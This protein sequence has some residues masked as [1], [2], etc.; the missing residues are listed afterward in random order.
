MKRSAFKV[1]GRGLLGDLPDHPDFPLAG[2]AAALAPFS[3]GEFMA[4]AVNTATQT[5]GIRQKRCTSDQPQPFNHTTTI[6]R[7]SSGPFALR[8]ES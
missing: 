5:D 7:V 8:S 3:M 2:T 1:W 4:A 6:S